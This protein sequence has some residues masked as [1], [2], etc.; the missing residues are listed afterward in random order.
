MKILAFAGTNSETSINRTLV[1]FTLKHFEGHDID[2]I[3][4]N[5][6][7]MPIYKIQREQ[8]SGI[9]QEAQLFAQ[10]IDESDLI[11]MALAEHNSAYTVAFKNLWDWSSRIK[12][13][14]HFGNKPMFVL[15]TAP[16]PGGGKNVVEVFMKRA[17][18]S[19]ANVLTTFSLPKY[20]ETFRV[21][22][23]IIDEEKKAEFQEKVELVKRETGI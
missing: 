6:Y 12:E 15:S 3:D 11:I 7:E 17:V 14:K 13:R 2:Y 23:G 16:G 18:P 20:G 9:P 22:E 10:K 5:D 21:G 1:E 4:L 19:G 8:E